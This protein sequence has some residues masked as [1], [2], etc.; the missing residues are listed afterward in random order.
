MN[1]NV[2]IAKELVKIA[3]SLVAEDDEMTASGGVFDTSI[4]IG[5]EKVAGGESFTIED[6][7]LKQ[8]DQNLRESAKSVGELIVDLFAKFKEQGL[9]VVKRSDYCYLAFNTA[10][11]NGYIKGKEDQYGKIGM[12]LD[13][14]LKEKGDKLGIQMRSAVGTGINADETGAKNSKQFDDS[15]IELKSNNTHV[16]FV[17]DSD[18]VLKIEGVDKEKQFQ[19]LMDLK[20]KLEDKLDQSVVDAFAK[21]LYKVNTPFIQRLFGIGK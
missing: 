6:D 8:K 5:S 1:R 15:F 19:M 3:K 13:C 21:K 18:S 14:G 4:T 17:H 11:V 10:Y 20:K 12:A 7:D 9:D 2:K 16:K